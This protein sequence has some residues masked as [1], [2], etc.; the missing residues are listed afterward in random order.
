[1]SHSIVR[2]PATIT[3]QVPARPLGRPRLLPFAFLSA[4]LLSF[5]V[6]A[7]AGPPL[8]IQSPAGTLS[9]TF[10]LSPK[11]EPTYELRRAKRRV[12]LPSRLGL[13]LKD[14]P[15]FLD[16]FTVLAAETS[17]VDDAWEPVWGEEKTIR[18]VYRELHVKL[19]QTSADKREIGI[20][21][22]LF[23]DG[24]GFRYVF[25]AQD[26]LRYFIV[27][28]EK[29]EFRLT[30]DHRAFWI[31]GD[32][33]TNEYTYTESK[34]SEVNA[35]KGRAF[36]EIAVRSIIG[37]N[38]VQS[39]LMMK[40]ADGLYINI[41][42]AALVNYP[43]MN[44]EIDKKKSI[45]TSTLV[46]DPVGNKAYMQ[47]PCVTPW[48]TVIVSESAADILRSRIVLNLN[49]PPAIGETD[50]IRPMKF[51]GVWWD[52]HVGTATWSYA[53]VNNVRLKGMDW[54]SL[55]PNGRHGAT[56]ERTKVYIDFAAKHG[57]QGVLVEGWNVGWE[58]WF[59]NWKEEVFDFVTPYPDFDVEELKEYAE[60]KGVKLI[61]H[62][63][64]SASVTNYERRM[65]EAFR[66]MKENGYDAVKTAPCAG[67]I[68]RS[69]MT[70]LPCA[71]A[72]T[73]FIL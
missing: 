64:T 67:H 72:A 54:K 31:P 44:L 2:S 61:M 43:A 28:D 71:G 10:S 12:I 66:F 42:E 57:I 59:G 65:D 34:L 11:G 7:P 23:D 63:E 73:A 48:R 50:W 47:T 41:F 1:M 14:Q 62:H 13:A 27:S 16:G 24:L 55:T 69:C 56:T 38:Y 32:Y 37:P 51:V 20:V 17:S 52:M 15:S 9:L 5:T 40:S 18:N 8:T 3:Q 58:D 53:D 68:S 22:R 6:P 26:K 60:D 25:P 29:T 70:T 4:I 46:P 36:V 30:G 21:F 33:D 45:L 19:Q 35:E 39:P 49:D